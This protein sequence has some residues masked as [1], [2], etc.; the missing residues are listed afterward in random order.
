MD[1][2]TNVCWMHIPAGTKVDNG[3]SGGYCT[4][5]TK[6]GFYTLYELVHEYQHKG[7]EWEF[8]HNN[9]GKL[10]EFRSEAEDFLRKHWKESAG[11]VIFECR[12]IVPYGRKIADFLKDECVACGGDW[13]KLLLS[14]IKK[15]FPNVYEAIPD[16]MGF[17]A[18]ECICYTC[19]LCGIDTTD[20]TAE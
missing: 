15:V 2:I 17:F 14:G 16:N 10:E 6:D 20:D 3:F 11:N 4:A 8:E 18:W 1:K 19:L 7:W 9:I 5:P 12:N 13:G